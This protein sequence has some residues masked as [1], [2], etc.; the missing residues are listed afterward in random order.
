MEYKRRQTH[1]NGILTEWNE[2][3]A[4]G[5]SQAGGKGW[6]LAGLARY[7]LPLPEAIVIPTAFEKEWLLP[8]QQQLKDRETLRADAPSALEKLRKELLAQ[9]LPAA[10]SSALVKALAEKGWQQLSLAVRSSAT[11]EDSNETSFAG[12]HLTRLNV[13]GLETLL[14]TVR[15]IWA[16]RWSPEAQAYRQRFGIKNSASGM[17]VVVMPM[18]A[19]KASG[20]AFTCDP[21]NGRDDRVIIHANWG[22]GESLV[23]GQSIGDEAI[24]SVNPRDD[25]LE[26]QDYKVGVKSSMTLAMDQ[27]TTTAI[28]PVDQATAKV[29]NPNEVMALGRLARSA[30]LALDFAGAAYDLEWAWD[31]EH[32]W[33]LQARPVTARVRNTYPELLEQPDIWSRGN[34]GEV[35]PEPLSALDWSISRRLVN[36][37]LEQN[38]KI[39][40]FPLLPG[41]QRAGLFH[42]RLYLNLSLMQWESYS[43]FGVL[44]EAMNSLLGGHQPEI[45]VTSPTAM[46]KLVQFQRMLK[47]VRGSNKRR[48]NADNVIDTVR[49]QA[50]VWRKKPLPKEEQA[51]FIALLEQIRYTSSAEHLFFLQVSSGGNLSLL[52]DLIEKRLPGE[53]HALAAALLAGGEPTITAQQAHDLAAL[54]YTAK[55]DAAVRDWFNL[56]KTGSDW[57]AGLAAESPFR[58]QFLSFLEKYGHRAVYESYFRHPRWREAPEYLLESIKGFMAHDLDRLAQQRQQGA[59]AALQKIEKNTPWWLKPILHRLKNAAIRDTRHREAARSALVALMEPQRRILLSIGAIWQQRGMLR[60]A[61]EIFNLTLSEIHDAVHNLTP[62]QGVAARIMD[63]KKQLTESGTAAA[64]EVLLRYDDLSKSSQVQPTP[65]AVEGNRFQGTAVGTGKARGSV[66]ILLTP[67]EGIRLKPGEI[68]AAPSTDPS[69]TPL[70][71]K[72]EGLIMETG[73]YLSHG[74]IVAREFGIPAVVNLPGIL[75]CLNTGDMVEVDGFRGQVE[76]LA[77]G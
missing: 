7:G 71:L 11:G 27:G 24:L 1:N 8:K 70:F 52:V 67:N 13:R 53:G 74:A 76:R 25:L 66:R 5:P 65:A 43:A 26:L 54:A 12:I 34:T 15:E 77:K 38:Q 69:W 45:E 35:M 32:F 21:R 19:A 4:A 57:D 29:L 2:I 50:D 60:Q 48:R 39:V 56:A 22:L 40:D 59:E 51:L 42:G 30:A 10:L 33:L 49:H 68:L 58:K 55:E 17:A 18:I 46:E 41:A 9:P 62:S 61:D 20:I 28:T 44:P 23:T 63:R 3:L 6:H 75:D 37:M 31:G 64:E 47:Y 36:L 14:S 73:G 16:S 72:A